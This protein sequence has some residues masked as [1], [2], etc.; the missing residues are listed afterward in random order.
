MGSKFSKTS[1]K[2][3]LR[4]EVTHVLYGGLVIALKPQ[5]EADA[6]LKPFAKRARLGT[7]IF[8]Q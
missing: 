8:G 2:S 5:V 4:R 7:P 3:F 6:Y 1:C